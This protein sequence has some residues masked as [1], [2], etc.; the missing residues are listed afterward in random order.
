M[1]EPS[2]PFL[3]LPAPLSPEGKT[4]L[5][6]LQ[7]R[8][9]YWYSTQPQPLAFLFLCEGSSLTEAQIQLLHRM[10][11]AAGLPTSRFQYI[12]Q[13]ACKE[14]E[15]LSRIQ[16]LR[17]SALLILGTC[18]AFFKALP[19][20]ALPPWRATWSLQALL[21]TPLRRKDTWASLMDLQASWSIP[22]KEL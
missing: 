6:W 20:A 4:Y 3:P 10:A 15:L 22:D 11:Q 13:E 14:E 16:E 21:D 5:S 9:C 1:Q 2:S 8:G 19:P 12:C 17:P 7:D 18:P